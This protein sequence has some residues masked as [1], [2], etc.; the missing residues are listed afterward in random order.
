METAA[1]QK[2]PVKVID[3][4]IMR[5]L[6]TGY[7]LLIGVL[8]IC[9]VIFHYVEYVDDFMS[10]GATMRLVF[11]EYYPNYIPEIVKLISPLALFLACIFLTSRL[12]EEMQLTAL[13]ASGVSL[14]RIFVPYVVVGAFWVA[15]MFF[16][17]GYLVPESNRFRLQ[18]ENQYFKDSDRKIDTNNLHRQNAPGGILTVRFFDDR[19]GT[20]HQVSLQ[21]YDADGRLQRRVDAQEMSWVDSLGIWR[22]RSPV[23]RDFY[24]DGEHRTTASEKDTLLNI[25]PR[26]LARTDRD[27]EALTIPESEEYVA[28]LERAGASDL[29]SALVLYHA[30]FAYPFANLV[31]MLLAF[32]FASVR[33]RRGKTV[34]VGIA[35]FV[36]FVYLAAMKLTE[37]FGY[38][39]ELH[40]VVTAWAPHLLFALF[41]GILLL[42]VPK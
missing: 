9:F 28:S 38:S 21:Q 42:R 24:Q 4:H 1:A 3:L 39:G 5:R 10:R 14:Y 30:K 11:L 40:P 20:A 27:V 18:F 31:V 7:V 15:V 8:V 29:S 26:D 6:T 12:A 25:L 13:L 34:Q 2:N 36:A 19:S 23:M 35:L 41:G 37:P 16:F 32:P 22:L 17:N 33:S